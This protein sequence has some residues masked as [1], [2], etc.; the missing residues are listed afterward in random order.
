M[1]PLVLKALPE[2]GAPALSANDIARA[3][4][5]GCP[6]TVRTILSQMVKAGIA[7][8]ES[9][10]SNRGGRKFAYTRAPS[11]Q[12]D[13]FESANAVYGDTD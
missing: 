1:I 3:V 7:V 9:V 11:L 10:A 13:D 5:F 2:P 8:S 12:P 4:I 6:S